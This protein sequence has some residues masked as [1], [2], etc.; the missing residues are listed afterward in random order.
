[1]REGVRQGF[2][3]VELL[4]VIAIVG[5]LAAVLVPN[6][7][8]AR[9]AAQDRATHGYVYQVVQGI[10]AERDKAG[11]SLPDTATCNTFTSLVTN[12]E[13]SVKQCKYEPNLSKNTYEV[14][15]QSVSGQVFHFNGE[16]II[17]RETY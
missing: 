14:T 2:T 10:E 12:P 11:K 6:L 13:G 8:Q 15:A 17:L 7:V 9:R 3:L 16:R 5:V 1:M 4:I